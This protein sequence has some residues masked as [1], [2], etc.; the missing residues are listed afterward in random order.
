MKKSQNPR[1]DFFFR[2]AKEENYPARSVYKLQEID[3]QFRIFKKGDV[4]LD[5]GCAPGSWMTY[6]AREIES[7]FVLGVDVEDINIPMQDNMRF[8]QDDIRNVSFD[9]KFD[10]IVSDMAP[11]TTGIHAVDV[12]R[13][14]ELVRVVL[15]IIKKNL[16]KH[17]NFVCKVF[18]GE[19]TDQLFVDFKEIFSIVKSVRPKAIRKQSREL[20]FVGK[21][22]KL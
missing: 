11:K 8:I 16:K 17:G 10:V 9:Q 6:I 12:A 14:L 4:V 15:E 3:K 2:K 7:S 5:V 21:N 18:E 13:S 22:K 19:G 20:Y 1:H